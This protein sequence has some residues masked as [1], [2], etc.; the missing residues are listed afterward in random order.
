MALQSTQLF[1]SQTYDNSGVTG[2]G[3]FE[4]ANIEFA[5]SNR[6]PNV[7]LVMDYEAVNPDLG[8]WGSWMVSMV[9]EGE[10][11]DGKFYPIAYQFEPFRRMNDG[12]QRIILVGPGVEPG[13]GVDDIVYPADH[14]EARISREQGNAA[15]SMRLRIRIKETN[16][17]GA[18]SF[19]SVTLSA[20][21]E[22]FD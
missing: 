7:R 2:N 10:R 16:Y 3:E 14:T 8:L 9:L 22:M 21:V 4:L 13:Q 18:Q 12:P 11:D 5:N 19:Q 20:Y 1:A 17:G 6:L 15:A